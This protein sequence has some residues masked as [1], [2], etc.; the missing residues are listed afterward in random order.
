ML[1]II[2]EFVWQIIG[3]LYLVK[4]QIIKIIENERFCY[5]VELL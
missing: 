3:I 2:V 5:V 1:I 4:I